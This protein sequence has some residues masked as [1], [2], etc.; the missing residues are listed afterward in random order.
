MMTALV[1]KFPRVDSYV[2]VKRSNVCYQAPHLMHTF[3]AAIWDMNMLPMVGVSL[4]GFSHI[5][6]QIW[7]LVLYEQ[8]TLLSEELHPTSWCQISVCRENQTT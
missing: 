2:C 1:R 8:E 6:S 5:G 7:L 3:C 4:M